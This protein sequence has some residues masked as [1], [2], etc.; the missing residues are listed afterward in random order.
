M[1]SVVYNLQFKENSFS[2]NCFKIQLKEVLRIDA[3][4]FKKGNR[5]AS[6]NQFFL[7]PLG[8][9]AELMEAIIP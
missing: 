9:A 5:D 6:N 4:F 8:V 7:P 3:E 1:F 2:K